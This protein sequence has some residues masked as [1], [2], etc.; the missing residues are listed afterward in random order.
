M[1]TIRVY[2]DS[3]TCEHPSES[4][5]GWWTKKLANRLKM[6]EVNLARSGSSI[7]YSIKNLANDVKNNRIEDDSIVIILISSIGRF[8]NKT[9]FDTFPESGANFIHGCRFFQENHPAFK[10]YYD[11]EDFIKWWFVENDLELEKIHVQNF[12]YWIYYIASKKYINN[13]FIIMFNNFENFQGYDYSYINNTEN[14]L[15][16]KDFSMTKVSNN[17]I[18]SGNFFDFVGNINS[19]PR[20]NHLTNPNI[21]I[22]VDVMEKVILQNDLSD[23]RYDRFLTNL[24]KPIKELSGYKKYTEEGILIEKDY[25]L[26]KFDK[27]L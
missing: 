19:D 24:L 25:I 15:L 6:N 5:D 1:K 11:N 2:G 16:L 10:Y 27:E 7:F 4:R 21:D 8:H 13:K 26:K 20:I 12:I 23:L 17:E 18:D 22:L 14:F 9:V 3:Y